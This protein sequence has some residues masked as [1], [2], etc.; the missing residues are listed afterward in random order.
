MNLHAVT[1]AQNKFRTIVGDKFHLYYYIAPWCKPRSWLAPFS[2]NTRS[3]WWPSPRKD[4]VSK[5][6][7]ALSL[8]G[9]SQS[10]NR[11]AWL[12]SYGIFSDATWPELPVLIRPLVFYK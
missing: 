7:G 4:E 1:R 5:V 6:V 8:P 10:H 9:S 2:A 3:L 12:P 11:A